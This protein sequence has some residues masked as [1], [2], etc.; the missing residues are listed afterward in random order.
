MPSACCRTWRAPRMR[1]RASAPSTRSAR[2]SGRAV[3]M[4][5]TADLSMPIRIGGALGFCGDSTENAAQLVQ[6]GDIDFLV[7]D[8]LAEITMSL[9][10]RIHTRKPELGYVP[11]FIESIVP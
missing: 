3:D 7:F 4:A 6:R 11:D 5:N 2:R 1:A 9:L 8:Y 10:A